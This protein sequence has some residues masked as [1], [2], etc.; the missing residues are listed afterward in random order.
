MD[1]KMD[2]TST[3]RRSLLRVGALGGV[4]A[5]AVLAGCG[6]T[7]VVTET[8]IQEVVKEVPVEKVVT[9]I[10]EK[11]KIVEVERVVTQEV[12]KIVIQEKVVTKIVEV[13]PM[14]KKATELALTTV[15]FYG[16]EEDK[17][18]FDE[19]FKIFKDRFGVTINP[20]LV[21][22]G[23]NAYYVKVLTQIAGG[24]PPD[25][26]YMHPEFM[27]NFAGK[28]SII[29]VDEFIKRDGLDMSDYYDNILEYFRFPSHTPGSRLYV[30]PFYSGPSLTI[31]N[32]DLFKEKGIRLPEEF[33]DDWTWDTI[34][35]VSAQLTGGTGGDKTFGFDSLTTR[36]KV[37]APM[38]WN[39]GGK[40]WNDDMTATLLNAPAAVQAFQQYADLQFK[41]KVAP[42]GADREGLAGGFRSGRVGI[43]AWGIKG[44]VPGL[45]AQPWN[46]AMWHAPSGPEGSFVR[47][48]PNGFAIMKAAKAPDE[49]WEL[50]K[51]TT[52]PDFFAASNSIGGTLPLT[53]SLM[54][55]PDFIQSLQ[56]WESVDIYEA[57]SEKDLAPRIP[58]T[59]NEIAKLTVGPALEL[60]FIGQ[61]TVQEAMDKVAPKVDELLAQSKVE[62]AEYGY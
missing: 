10:V 14:M 38:V 30:L 9:Q 37:L 58:T 31:V 20:T 39:F 1:G 56:P 7:Q 62:L 23:G 47:N 49:A 18:V 42:T 4:G 12:E 27:G 43:S 52:G 24:T 48:G 3:S 32:A 17:I 55:G 57:A 50:M 25:A 19:T 26:L 28:G 29:P 5:V 34:H 2:I 35:E 54:R 13:A 46:K 61:D 44:G 22:G 8:R 16:V 15:R 59:F 33:G 53:R 41:E 36:L 6:E 60:A 21:P 51:F 45:N 40:L 11:E